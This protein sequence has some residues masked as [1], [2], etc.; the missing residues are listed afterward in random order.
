M[1]YYVTLT[2]ARTMLASVETVG[3]ALLRAHAEASRLGRDVEIWDAC[4]ALVYSVTREGRGKA[5]GWGAA[6]MAV[7]AL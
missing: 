2:D 7:G 4:G 5:R 6:V 3:D 1:G